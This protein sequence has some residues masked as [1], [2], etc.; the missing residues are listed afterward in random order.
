M[1]DV[2][3]LLF[4]V[5]VAF[6]Y[7]GHGKQQFYGCMM[8]AASIAIVYFTKTRKLPFGFKT[9]LDDTHGSACFGSKR[10]VKELVKSATTLP[11]KGEI[12]LAP[13]NG[14][15]KKE[16]LYLPRQEAVRH[17]L[18]CGGSG[19]GKSYGFFLP[20][21][22]NYIGSF[23]ATDPKNEL[24]NKTAAFGVSA[25]YAPRDP[26][27]SLCLNWIPLCKDDSNLALLLA[28][29]IVTA[30]GNSSDAFWD[31]SASSLIAGLFSHAATFSN[32]TPSAMFDFFNAYNTVELSKILRKSPSQSARELSKTF[33][34]ASPN[35]QGSIIATVASKLNFMSDRK[36]RR[37]TSSNLRPTN[38]SVLRQRSIRVYWCL[39]ETDVRQLQPLSCLFFALALYQIKQASGKIPITMFLDELANIGKI[40][41]LEVEVAVVRGRDI[42]LVLGLQ[43]YSQLFSIYGERAGQVILDNC[44]TKI[45]L[46]GL[47][48]DV[49]ENVSRCL[50][51]QTTTEKLEDGRTVKT[52]RRLL[53]ADEVRQLKFQE[54]LIITGNKKPLRMSR[55]TY[56]EPER[57]IKLKPLPAE[58]TQNFDTT[59]KQRMPPLPV[60][61]KF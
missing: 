14:F 3:G 4:I 60:M 26:D 61:P 30:S 56:D 40:P 27:N 31:Q 38:L 52:Q 48:G 23:I 37:F 28:Q 55:F 50:G 15:F 43:S 12:L 29:S 7:F 16:I 57:P 33:C 58:I 10:D 46:S 2:I 34:D 49:A 39:E 25:R 8:V 51:V 6:A 11:G 13:L 45:F 53:F 5:G 20:N 22:R 36:V 18:I 54:Q 24:W 35:T 44:S 17:V 59:E 21:C 9:N 47:T 32:P 1:N 42:A 41:G 19:S